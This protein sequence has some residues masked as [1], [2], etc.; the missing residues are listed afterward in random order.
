MA[1][2][3]TSPLRRSTVKPEVDDGYERPQQEKKILAAG[4]QLTHAHAPFQVGTIWERNVQITMRDGCQIYVDIFRPSDSPEEKVPA[5]LTWSPYGKSA[6]RTGGLFYPS[7]YDP[8]I[9]DH[10]QIISRRTQHPRYN[11]GSYWY[12]SKPSV[13]I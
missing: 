12:S 8:L 4:W 1:T 7:N 2:L 10:A 9:S 11:S 5:L 6:C 13:W 3:I